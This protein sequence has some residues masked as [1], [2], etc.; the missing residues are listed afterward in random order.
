DVPFA[1]DELNT[2]LQLTAVGQ[3][4]GLTAQTTFTDAG[5]TSFTLDFP[6]NGATYNAAGYAAGVTLGGGRT[7]PGNSIAGGVNFDNSSTAGRAVAVSIKR[8]TDNLYWD[9]T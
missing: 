3:T 7:L 8:N 2:T 6:A 9:G 5:I 1:E 4:S